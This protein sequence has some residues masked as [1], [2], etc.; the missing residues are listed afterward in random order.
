MICVAWALGAVLVYAFQAR[1][2]DS[3]VPALFGLA[4]YVLTKDDGYRPGG[5]GGGGSVKYWRGR[6]VDD[7]PP[8]RWN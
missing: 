1:T 3:L 5:G 2:L 6:P 7:R 4:A 8:R